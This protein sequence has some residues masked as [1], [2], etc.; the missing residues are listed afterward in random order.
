MYQLSFFGWFKI[1][2][3]WHNL[4]LLLIPL[5]AILT[6]IFKDKHQFIYAPLNLGICALI[7]FLNYPS[8]IVS[9]H[10][11]PIYYDDLVIKDYNEEEA[12]RFY[13]NQF[14]RKYQ[15]VFRTAIAITS[16]ILVVITVELWYYRE[17]IFSDDQENISQ[18]TQ[19]VKFVVI[20]SILG[21]LLRI[22]YGATML[23]G[24]IVMF[25]LKQLKKREQ[26]KIRQREQELIMYHL[27]S[28]GIT[29]RP[30]TR[31]RQTSLTI[32]NE[33]PDEQAIIPPRSHSFSGAQTEIN[34]IGFKPSV[35]HD[36]FGD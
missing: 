18:Q 2:L 31:T 14:R 3:Y 25:I 20:I 27:T 23:I 1:K 30:N 5:I 26:R 10:S 29:V 8:I 33:E 21:G 6:F 7:L 15:K 22:Y 28:D 32:T 36:I 19:L 12:Q 4:T 34:V 11:R 9:L 16:S 17:K 35:M 24:K 13:D